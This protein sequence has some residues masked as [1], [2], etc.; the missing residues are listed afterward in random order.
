MERND[1]ETKTAV[2][3]RNE[4]TVE[5]AADNATVLLPSSDGEALQRYE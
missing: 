3:R 2:P 5:D 1:E 4:D